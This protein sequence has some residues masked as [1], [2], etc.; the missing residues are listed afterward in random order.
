MSVD[1]RRLRE[2]ASQT[3]FRAETLERVI[4]LGE[5]AGDVARHPLLS[6]ALVLK[7]GTAINLCFGEPRRLSVDLDFNYIGRLEK[8]EMEAER[9]DIERSLQNIAEGRGY[10]TQQSAQEH[11]GRKL[12]LNYQGAAGTPG[13]IEVDVNY[14]YRLPLENRSLSVSGS[15]RTW[16]GLQS[17]SSAPTSSRAESSWHSWIASRPETPMTSAACPASKRSTGPGLDYARSF[18]PC[19]SCSPIR[20][21]RTTAGVFRD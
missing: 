10:K 9:P 20:S 6:R 11:G 8:G 7:G 14:L 13:R 15:R 21:T 16:R 18:S 5:I 1:P 12:Y 4:R 17:P 2:L 19:R 3:G